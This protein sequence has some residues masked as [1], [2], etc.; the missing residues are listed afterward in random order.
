MS[1]KDNNK[2][3]ISAI[4][5]IP[6]TIIAVVLAAV[7]VFVFFVPITHNDCDSLCS[8]SGPY[9]SC[10]AVCVKTYRTTWDI[11]TNQKHVIGY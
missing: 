5:I 10:P 4:V 7:V 6:I 1:K 8:E 3:L 11:I 2:K 9:M